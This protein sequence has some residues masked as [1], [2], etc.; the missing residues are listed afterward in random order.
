MLHWQ[1]QPGAPESYLSLVDIEGDLIYHLQNHKM[2]VILLLKNNYLKKTQK[3]TTILPWC[4]QMGKKQTNKQIIY[5]NND[6][7]GD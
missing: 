3:I 6:N 2:N 7:K 1:S 5:F 4:A